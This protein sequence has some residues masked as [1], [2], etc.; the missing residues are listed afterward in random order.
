M[1]IFQSIIT[2]VGHS[3]LHQGGVTWLDRA[4]GWRG[5][6]ESLGSWPRNMLFALV[7]SY[8]GMFGDITT[9]SLNAFD[10]AWRWRQSCIYILASWHSG[11]SL[12][13]GRQLGGSAQ[14]PWVQHEA[15]GRRYC[16]VKSIWQFL[17]HKPGENIMIIF[18][19][20]T[21]LGSNWPQW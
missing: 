7:N 10:G 18:R 19:V 5:N 11:R 17:I 15:K 21:L 9:H 20:F 3:L 4:W 14:N 13:I 12:D 8:P 16:R 2:L 6:L 1:Y